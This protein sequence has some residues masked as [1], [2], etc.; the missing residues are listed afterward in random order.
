MPDNQVEDQEED[1]SAN[2]LIPGLPCLSRKIGVGGEKDKKYQ[3]GI[4]ENIPNY[5][6]EL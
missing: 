2:Y 5:V 4:E 1:V 6:E 3:I